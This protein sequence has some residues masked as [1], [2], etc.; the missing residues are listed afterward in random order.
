MSIL[1]F[2]NSINGINGLIKSTINTANLLANDNNDVKI[3]ICCDEAIKGGFKEFE[4]TFKINNDIEI[5]SIKS[6]AVDGGSFLYKKFI[7]VFT[8]KQQFLRAEF[9][10][11]TCLWCKK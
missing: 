9:L 1:I 10:S 6:L 11:M 5:Y 8:E 2:A 4:N 7:K 3:I